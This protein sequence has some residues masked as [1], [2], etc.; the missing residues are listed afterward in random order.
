MSLFCFVF[1]YIFFYLSFFCFY[2]SI[3]LF[4]QSYDI[5][6]IYSCSI[7]MK[8]HFTLFCMMDTGMETIEKK[9]CLLPAQSG[10]LQVHQ[11]VAEQARTVLS[12]IIFYHL[13]SR[14]VKS[15]MINGHLCC[16]NFFA[17]S[18]L[19]SNLVDKSKPF[20]YH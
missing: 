13:I 16:H 3:K 6:Q 9:T 4:F 2:F 18:K 11:I 7:Y 20:G 17:F 5:A 19:V 1:L 12:S 10:K 15:F 8:Q 14:T